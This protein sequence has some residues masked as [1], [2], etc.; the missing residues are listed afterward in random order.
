MTEFD[1]KLRFL[2]KQIAWIITFMIMSPFCIWGIFVGVQYM[3]DSCVRD[4]PF[5]LAL[6]IWII[7]KASFD[8]LFALVV[9]LLLCCHTRGAIRRW[10]IWPMHFLN[11]GWTVVGIWLIV[12][13]DIRCNHNTLWIASVVLTCLTS[14]V[15]LSLFIVW[16]LNRIG[17]CRKLGRYVSIE[18][19]PYDYVFPAHQATAYYKDDEQTFDEETF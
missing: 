16:L 3:N 1:T 10:I 8:L 19:T 4:S 2:A 15:A 18:D 6:D 9:L 7:A 17:L 12:E 14:F 11:I 5:S 13:S